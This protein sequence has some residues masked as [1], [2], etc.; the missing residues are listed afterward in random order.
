MPPLWTITCAVP[1]IGIGF[2]C[3]PTA[4]EGMLSVGTLGTWRGEAL[5]SL[6]WKQAVIFQMLH[7]VSFI[8]YYRVL[9]LT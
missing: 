2:R 3:G 6:S 8:K 1:L 7:V 9:N 4:A 5:C